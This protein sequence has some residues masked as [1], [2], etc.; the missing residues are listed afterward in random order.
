MESRY[1][2]YD[3]VW[4]KALNTKYK[5]FSNVDFVELFSSTDDIVYTIPLEFNYRP[6]LIANY[7]YGNPK[8]YWVLIFVNS[9]SDSPEGFEAG[10]EIKIPSYTKVVE[11]L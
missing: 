5:G 8:L 11:A 10:K 2:Y 6:D 9:I 7:F 1:K 4:N 3:T